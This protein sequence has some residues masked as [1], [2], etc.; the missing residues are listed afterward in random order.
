MSIGRRSWGGGVSEMQVYGLEVLRWWE[1][2]GVEARVEDLG[3][4]RTRSW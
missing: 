2:V 4:L 3:G 1:S